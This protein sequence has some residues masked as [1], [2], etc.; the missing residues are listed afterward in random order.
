MDEFRVSSNSRYTGNSAFT[1]ETSAYAEE[2]DNATG[3]FVSTATTANASVT[4]MGAVIL[5]KNEDG[6]NAL[7]TDIVLQVSA[8]GGSNY[9]TA[10]LTAGGTFSTGITFTHNNNFYY[11]SKN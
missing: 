4:T 10:T 5:Y 2:I 11:R 7:N 3:N 8:D 6:V 9:T 1:P